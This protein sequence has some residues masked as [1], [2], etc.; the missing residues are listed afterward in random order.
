MGI[1]LALAELLLCMGAASSQ[2]TVVPPRQSVLGPQGEA[3]YGPPVFVELES[4]AFSPETHQRQ[5]VRTR[6][7]LDL[8]D[9]RQQFFLLIDGNA[10]VLLI[11]ASALDPSDL[12]RLLGGQVELRGIVRRVR[13]KEYVGPERIDLDLIEDPSLP[14]LPDPE[15]VSLPT[16]VTITVLSFSDIEPGAPKSR[17]AVTD[18]ESAANVK[19]DPSYW[20]SKKVRLA[21]LFRGRNLF[22]DLPARSQRK[23]TDWVLK[24]GDVAF[25]VTEK[26][27]KGK[28]WS[29]DPSY[30]GD[31]VRWLEV[32]GIP[33]V[34]EGVLYLRASQVRLTKKPDAPT[35]PE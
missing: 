29:L 11:L 34:A 18:R 22:G 13:K 4:I 10:R 19:S 5:H 3:D 20:A 8:F 24:D 30:K 25:W 6:G 33:E 7:R 16:T 27:P 28:G 26:E 31:A 12:M 17:G 2:A 14:I 32:V 21:G 15:K 1:A 9:P 35:E 23:P